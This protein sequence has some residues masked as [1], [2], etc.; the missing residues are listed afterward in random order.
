MG[1]DLHRYLTKNKTK[2]PQMMN[3]HMKRYLT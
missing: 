2:L 1:K 3:K